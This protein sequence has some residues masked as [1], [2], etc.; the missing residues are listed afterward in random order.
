MPIAELCRQLDGGFRLTTQTS[1]PRGSGLG[2][3]SIVAGAVLHC[4]SRFNGET[5]SLA[6]LFDEV[7]C[8]EQMLTTGGG[9]QDQ[10]GGLWGGLKLVSTVPGLP[11][12]LHVEPVRLSAETAEKL[13]RRLLLV[14][15]GRQ[16]LAKDL[17]RSV[18]GRWMA[19]D[20]EMVWN[21]QTIAQL[22]VTMRAALEAGD[23]D[24]CG[25]LLG[26]HW[27]INQR[28][29]PGCTNAFIDHLF[30]VMRPYIA[31]GK[32]AGAGGGG[33]AIVIAKNRA[34][35]EELESVLADVY[36]GTPVGIW[37]CAIAETGLVEVSA[38]D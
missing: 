35:A 23:V 38:A 30:E 24:S 5:E 4:L 15:T 20:P 32:L 17:L 21:Q 1:I 27:A 37:P 10:V 36:R 12:A 26:E 3:S 8:L 33:F 25:A 14:Y 9:W 22:A 16:R 31:G 13:A 2:T 18:M 7:L 34:A 28:M 29:D 6:D 19:R 11:Q